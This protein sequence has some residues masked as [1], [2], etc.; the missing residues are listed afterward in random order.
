MK[1]VFIKYQNLGKNLKNNDFTIYSDNGLASPSGLSSDQLL[2]GSIVQIPDGASKVFVTPNIYDLVASGDV[3]ILSGLKF[4]KV[5]DTPIFIPGSNNY[6]VTQVLTGSNINNYRFGED[7]MRISNNGNVIIATKNST[8]GVPNTGLFI[9]TG[10]SGQNWALRQTIPHPSGITNPAG[11]SSALSSN[12][13]I[14]ATSS[15]GINGSP[16]FVF[17]YT[18]NPTGGWNLFQTITGTSI[19]SG[20]ARNIVINEANPFFS[21]P[22]YLAATEDKKI[23]VYQYTATGYKLYKTITHPDIISSNSNIAMSDTIRTSQN[24]FSSCI[25]IGTPS[26]SGAL[27][28]KQGLLTGWAFVKKITGSQFDGSSVSINRSG[29]ILV[30]G[31]RLGGSVGGYA[32]IYTGRNILGSLEFKQQIS[33]FG[34][35]SNF[36]GSIS[37]K[38]TTIVVGAPGD[39]TLGDDGVGRIYIYTGSRENGWALNRSFTGTSVPS[40]QLGTLVDIY[41]NTV[42]ASAPKLSN[43][44]AINVYNPTSFTNVETYLSEKNLHAIWKNPV[45]NIWVISNPTNIGTNLTS[46]GGFFISPAFS[47]ASTYNLGGSSGDGSSGG[48]TNIGPLHIFSLNQDDG[49]SG[50]GLNVGPYINKL[51]VYNTPGI[52]G[53]A[54]TYTSGTFMIQGTPRV[55]FQNDQNPN[56]YIYKNDLPSAWRAVEYPADYAYTAFTW[57]SRT[58]TQGVQEDQGEYPQ[59]D[60]WRLGDNSVMR[61]PPVTDEALPLPEMNFGHCAGNT[62]IYPIYTYQADSSDPTIDN[63]KFYSGGLL[64]SSGTSDLFSANLNDMFPDLYDVYFDRNFYYTNF[65]N[66]NRFLLF[67]VFDN[68]KDLPDYYITR[69]LQNY[70]SGYFYWQGG[71][72]YEFNTGIN[73][74]EQARKVYTPIGNN[75]NGLKN[76][77]INLNPLYSNQEFG[78]ETDLQLATL[79]SG[80]NIYI[81]VQ[82]HISGFENIDNIYK[83]TVVNSI[84]QTLDTVFSKNISTPFTG[85]NNANLFNINPTGN[86]VDVVTNKPIVIRVSGNWRNTSAE[87]LSSPDQ[88]D[89]ENFLLTGS[90]GNRIDSLSIGSGIFTYSGFAPY[91]YL[92]IQNVTGANP[93]GVIRTSIAYS[94]PDPSQNT[95]LFHCLSGENYIFASP[96]FNVNKAKCWDTGVNIWSV[97][98]S[99]YNYFGIQNCSTNS[100]FLPS[101][102]WFTG[103]WSSFIGNRYS[104]LRFTKLYPHNINVLYGY[105][106]YENTGYN[107]SKI[108]G[109]FNLNTGQSFVFD[110]EDNQKITGYLVNRT[111]LF[112][113]GILNATTL[114]TAFQNNGYQAYNSGIY[115]KIFIN[116][117]SKKLTYTIERSGEKTNIRKYFNAIPTS[118]NFNK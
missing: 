47:V 116:F 118:C 50:G 65:I 63:I 41:N 57:Y 87:W 62:L 30:L 38:D 85:I 13:D 37:I 109:I 101:K 42:I 2:A 99:E 66:G 81:D 49:S 115:S 20:F 68:S 59:V 17:I 23:S 94:T 7:S 92:K 56:F 26:S 22:S 91:Q 83:Y 77:S 71:I 51:H 107:Y 88:I 117:E 74:L 9:F 112:D 80:D 11:Y 15:W 73:T 24:A 43:Y 28:Y 70:N 6:N 52:T 106:L 78:D 55:G 108:S 34:F 86:I 60:R 104:N 90:G 29:D 58:G 76:I 69:T 3:P 113:Y 89:W 61:P 111:N 44:G 93:T 110:L 54:G 103:V 5:N 84:P 67:R 19:N 53:F 102:Y 45:M 96:R 72:D 46:P 64:S 21:G 114:S 39:V 31:N 33:G 27:V 75:I 105:L 36:A 8:F 4:K 10:V 18:G 16:G 40:V 97:L 12:G 98:D 25:V 32:N 48:G 35:Q 14:I 79:N 100:G 1:P 82:P 95:G